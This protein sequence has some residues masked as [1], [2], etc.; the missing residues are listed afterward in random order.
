MAEPRSLFTGASVPDGYRR[1]LEP[2]IFQPWAERLLDFVGIEAGQRVLDVASGTGVVARAAARRVGAAGH[3]IASDISAA[4]LAH[5]T[6]N[7]APDAATV[8]TLECSATELAV[9]DATIDA[10]LCQQGLPFIPDRIAAMRE[11]E[12]VLRPGGRAGV[13]VWLSNP[14]LEPFLIYGEALRDRGL[15]EPFP[16]AYDSTAT[17]M[18]REDVRDAFAAAGF[19]E[20][21][22]VTD[23]LEVGWASAEAAAEAVVGTPYGPVLVALDPSARDQVMADIRHR[24]TGPDGSVTKHVTTAVLARGVAA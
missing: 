5:V 15:P 2:V 7:L 4:M 20:I 23:D 21:E 18:G 10:V 16:N 6:A 11:M 14:R 9:G 24:M 13:A 17:S 3:V 8:E 12:R 22:V 19:R 1:H